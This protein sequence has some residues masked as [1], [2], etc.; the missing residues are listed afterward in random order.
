[1]CNNDDGE[2]V[3]TIP[4]FHVILVK[5]ARKLTEVL[6]SSWSTSETPKLIHEVD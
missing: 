4:N 2:Y 3:F 6:K 1:M 5:Y